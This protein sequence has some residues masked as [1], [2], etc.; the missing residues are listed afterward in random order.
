[1]YSI[2]QYICFSFHVT[3]APTT[4]HSFTITL[5]YYFRVHEIPVGTKDVSFS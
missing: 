2:Q 4:A 5:A 3:S 1:M